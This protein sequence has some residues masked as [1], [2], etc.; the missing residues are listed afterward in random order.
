MLRARRIL[1]LTIAGLVLAVGASGCDNAVGLSASDLEVIPNPAHVGDTVVF[2]FA[3]TVVPRQAF[4]ISIRIDG[5]EHSVESRNEEIND[6]VIH[7]MGD[8]AGLISTYGLGT[9]LGSVQIRLADG[10]RTA[11]STRTF[12]LQD[13]PP[14]PP[15]PPAPPAPARR[16]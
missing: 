15:P 1:G 8:A 7:Q 4:T 2:V 5:V 11:T 16:H 10:G 12:E 9:H 3:I 13:P 6:L 14:P